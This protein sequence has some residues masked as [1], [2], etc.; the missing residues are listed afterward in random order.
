MPQNLKI[1]KKMPKILQELKHIETTDVSNG[2]IN[3]VNMYLNDRMT[4]HFSKRK[5]K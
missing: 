2:V 5:P 1:W 4:E 3:Y